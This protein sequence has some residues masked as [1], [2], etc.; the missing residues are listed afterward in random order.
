MPATTS[1][2]VTGASRAASTLVL[3]P[4]LM[5][6]HTVWDPVFPHLQA[7]FPGLHCIVADHGPSDSLGG[8]ADRILAADTYT[9]R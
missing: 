1:P 3:V 4:G 9:P 6:D 2:H 5:C 8:M 7:A